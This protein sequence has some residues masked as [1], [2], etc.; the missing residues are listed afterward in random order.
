ME[1]LKVKI[2][3]YKH[4]RH[5]MCVMLGAA[6]FSFPYEYVDLLM[7]MQKQLAEKLDI[8]R[9]TIG[10]WMSGKSL[11]RTAELALNLMLENRELQKRLE[12]FKI[13]KDAL[14]EL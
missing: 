10:R 7:I 5:I 12:S 9:G 3:D 4:D 6:G 13:F 11:P 14:N 2:K 8:P 1:T